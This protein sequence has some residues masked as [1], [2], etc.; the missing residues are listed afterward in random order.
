MNYRLNSQTL[1]LI[2]KIFILL[3]V[4]K[5]IGLAIYISL[6][7]SGVDTPKGEVIPNLNAYGTI[8]GPRGDATASATQVVTPVED[9]K[10]IAVYREVKGDKGFAVVQEGSEVKILKE[11]ENLGRYKLSEI[12]SDGIFLTESGRQFWVGFA[13]GTLNPAPP[14]S[15]IIG[16]PSGATL[17]AR[18]MRIEQEL[19]ASQAA[20]QPNM[21]E[22][23]NVIQKGELN[24]FLD[25][26]DSVFKNIGFK[27][28]VRNGKL[29]GFRVLSVNRNSPFAKLGL[30]AGDIIT[31]FNGVQLDNY[32]RVLEIYNNAK[33]YSRVRIE[34]M[35]NNI[36]K[37]FEYEIR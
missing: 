15:A 34:V 18:D 28:V 9:I 29:E 11:G 31:S 26:P 13:K 2:F 22:Y 6:P 23:S 17:L 24:Q 19:L 14:A 3:A 25:N 5:I 27:E 33:T 1:S 8:F 12:K 36:K 7:K 16:P 35:R 37:D 32:S 30:R 20:G 4:A 21:E 10:L